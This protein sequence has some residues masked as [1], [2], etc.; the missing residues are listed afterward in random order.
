MFT[1]LLVIFIILGLVLCLFF[2]FLFGLVKTGRRAD[3]NEEKFMNTISSSANNSE[4]ANVVEDKC[5]EKCVW[6]D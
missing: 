5:Q 6:K 4:P 3:K 2:A 1:F